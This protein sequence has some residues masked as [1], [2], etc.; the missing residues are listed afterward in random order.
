MMHFAEAA[1]WE[2][3]PAGHHEA[4]GGVWLKIAKKGAPVTSVTVALMTWPRSRVDSGA[5][6]VRGQMDVTD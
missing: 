2:S 3:W 1:Q 5:D 4:E 6:R